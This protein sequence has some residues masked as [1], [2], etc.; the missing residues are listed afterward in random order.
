M[1]STKPIRTDEDLDS[2]VTR[3]EEIFNA[4]PGSEE[5][6]ELGVLLDLVERYEDKHFHIEFPAPMSSIETP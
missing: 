2:A 1:S 3:L 5:D 4:E 6:D